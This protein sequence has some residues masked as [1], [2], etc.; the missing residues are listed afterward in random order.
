[1]R[2]EDI[3]WPRAQMHVTARKNGHSTIYPVATTVGH[4][5]VDY[6]K[7]GRPSVADRP[8][9]LRA[10]APFTPLPSSAIATRAS[11]YLHVAGVAAPRAGSQVTGDRAGVI[12]RVVAGDVRERQRATSD[13][14]GGRRRGRAEARGR[15][16]PGDAREADTES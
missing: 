15:S 8:I 2:L 9:F 11:H 3:D 4:A 16:T 1:L 6:L 14:I 12:D 7:A 13:K 10:I 5:L